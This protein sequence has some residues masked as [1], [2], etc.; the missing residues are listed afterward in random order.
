[1][2]SRLVVHVD[3]AAL[4]QDG[5]GCCELEDGPVIAP[6][7]ARRLGCDAELVARIEL[8]GLPLSVG[9]TRRT[10]PP[11][12]RRLLEARDDKTCVFPGCERSGTWRRTTA[13]TGPTAAPPS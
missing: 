10:V 9:R 12:L 11:A 13:T 8:D 6:E 7:T 4:T 5:Q 2:G 3:A 1:M